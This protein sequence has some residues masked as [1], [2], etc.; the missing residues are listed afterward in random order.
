MHSYTAVVEKCPATG[1]NVGYIPD[2]P[3][4]HPQAKSLDELHEKLKEVVSRLSKSG[5]PRL[6]SQFVGAR[7]R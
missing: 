6:D 7:R 2:F 5:P 1:F 3:G 4:A